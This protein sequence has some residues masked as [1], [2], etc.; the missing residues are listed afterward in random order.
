MTACFVTITGFVGVFVGAA[1]AGVVV[2]ALAAADRVVARGLDRVV[3]L[4]ARG[5][6][7]ERDG[8]EGGG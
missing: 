5:D 7:D 2:V 8:A 1:F 3:C 4:G 6:E